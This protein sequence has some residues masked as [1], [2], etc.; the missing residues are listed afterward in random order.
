MISN[1]TTNQQQLVM[2]QH[3][4]QQQQVGQNSSSSSSSKSTVISSQ[5][6][7]RST[8]SSGPPDN[9][10]FV[11]NLSYFCEEDHLFVLF[12]EYFYNVANVRIMRNHDRT[13]SL[14]YGFVATTSPLEA[15]EMI[16]L[17]NGHL[18]MGRNIR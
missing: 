2:L 8:L 10:V 7:P 1:H 15:V 14:M 3:P 18:F 9:E 12:S 17:L 5:P 6:S 16:R 13:R 11:G 4:Q